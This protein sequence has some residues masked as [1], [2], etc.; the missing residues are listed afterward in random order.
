LSP[1]LVVSIIWI[2]FEIILS[3]KKK[4][5]GE[6]NKDDRS[7]LTVLWITLIFFISVGIYIHQFNFGTIYIYSSIIHYI[8]L[9]LIVLGLIIRWFAILKLKEFFTVTVSIQKDHRV[10]DTGI[11]KYS[12]HP[13]YLGSLLSFLGLGLALQNWLSILVIFVPIFC[14]LSYR[15]YVEEKVLIEEFGEVYL[16]YSVRTKKLIPWIY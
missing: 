5:S 13:A 15:I 1:F 14:A 6:N 8:G 2:T 12:R 16:S 11:Y 10:V 7:S 9:V 4:S 3:R